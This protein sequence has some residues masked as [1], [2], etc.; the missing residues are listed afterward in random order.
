LCEYIQ[1]RH[2]YQPEYIGVFMSRDLPGLRFNPNAVHETE[3]ELAQAQRELA[4]V[5]KLKGA[6]GA[7][8]VRAIAETGTDPL[9]FA[10]GMRDAINRV[11]GER[12]RDALSAIIAFFTCDV[13]S[14]GPPRGTPDSPSKARKR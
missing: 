7:E 4:A 14:S 12:K 2:Y 6:L 3:E 11:D 9:S 13:E 8:N 5:D 1:Q 10:R